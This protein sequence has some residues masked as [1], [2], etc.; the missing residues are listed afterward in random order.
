MGPI[1][2]E[3]FSVSEESV[4]LLRSSMFSKCS[5]LTR[6]GGLL[7]P[8]SFAGMTTPPL[9]LALLASS[10]EIFDSD[11]PD[12][13]LTLSSGNLEKRCVYVKTN[14]SFSAELSEGRRFRSVTIKYVSETEL[15]KLT[16][17]AYL[18][19]LMEQPDASSPHRR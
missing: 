14:E 17:S 1:A 13:S 9:L 16:S 7:G 15:F 12:P 5:V 3:A 10:M 2:G 6:F 18:F 8:I 11:G 19:G 4:S